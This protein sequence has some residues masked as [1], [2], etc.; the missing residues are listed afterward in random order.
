MTPQAAALQVLT[1]LKGATRGLFISL[2]LHDFFMAPSWGPSPAA[3][4][5][6][7]CVDERARQAQNAAMLVKD[8]ITRKLQDAFAPD[9]VEV[10]DES[11]QHHGHAG[12]R[13]GGQT[14]FR[15]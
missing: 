2:D 9:S 13:P 7:S 10:A 15:V 14:H 4:A 12:H 8:D 6:F 11:D 3:T 5:P 1:S